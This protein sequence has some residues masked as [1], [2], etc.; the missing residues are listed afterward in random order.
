MASVTSGARFWDD[1]SDETIVAE[2]LSDARAVL[3][4]LAG[5]TVTRSLVVRERHATLSLTPAADAVRP[6]AE[7]PLANLLLAG[8]WV[9]TGLPATIEGAVQSGRRAAALALTVAHDAPHAGD[10]GRGTSGIGELRAGP[11]LAAH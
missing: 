2:V 5:T 4:A 3:P 8:D 10:L 9:R 6:G 7:T 1:A 11:S